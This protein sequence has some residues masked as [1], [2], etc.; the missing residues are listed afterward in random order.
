MKTI[1]AMERTPQEKAVAK[2]QRHIYRGMIRTLKKKNF[3]LLF[4][5]NQSLYT[6]NKRKN[7]LE[8]V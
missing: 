2:L 1:I 3:N 6:N 7:A 4:G 8:N 5:V